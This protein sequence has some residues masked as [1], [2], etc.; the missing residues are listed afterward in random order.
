[1]T[2][3]PII[4]A[5]SAPLWDGYVEGVIRIPSCDSCGHH[6]L[7]PGPVCPKCFGDAL[8]WRI[9]SGRGA[10]SSWV[11]IHRKYF[12][13]FTPPYLVVQVEL[14]EGPRLT[15][16]MNIEDLPAIRLGSRVYATCTKAL[17]GMVLPVFHPANEPAQEAATHN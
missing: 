12:E 11:V 5:D 8:T 4:S 15:A 2:V 17:N 6:H 13:D 14:D 3:T 10:V 1:M 9:A 7:P 16:A